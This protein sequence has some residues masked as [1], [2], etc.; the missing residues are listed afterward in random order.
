MEFIKDL[1]N[2]YKYVGKHILTYKKE[3]WCSLYLK[4]KAMGDFH[5][6]SVSDREITQ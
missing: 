4:A 6:H 2:I 1:K 3:S 5:N